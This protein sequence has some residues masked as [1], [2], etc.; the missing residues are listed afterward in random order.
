MPKVIQIFDVPDKVYDKLEA[1]AA[2][3]GLTLSDY[4]LF[5]IKFLSGSEEA[6]D[7]PT[8]AETLE[9]LSK[10]PPRTFKE[11]AATIIRRHRDASEVD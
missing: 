4:L 10:L 7:K 11:D 8:L 9:R 3:L 5:E 2:K 1:R 6:A